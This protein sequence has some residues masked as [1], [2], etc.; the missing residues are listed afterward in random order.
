MLFGFNIDERPDVRRIGITTLIYP[1]HYSDDARSYPIV[2]LL[3]C[4]RRRFGDTVVMIFVNIVDIPAISIPRPAVCLFDPFLPI[5]YLDRCCYS[6]MPLLVCHYQPRYTCLRCVLFCSSSIVGVGD[7]FVHYSIFYHL[8][9]YNY[10]F[11]R[12]YA[13]TSH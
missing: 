13:L 12:L 7:G 4:Y 9:T 2:L 1:C 6:L 10:L 3:V 5:H 8:P 11:R